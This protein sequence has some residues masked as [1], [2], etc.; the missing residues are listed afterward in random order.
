[1]RIVKL[2]HRLFCSSQIAFAAQTTVGR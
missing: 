1:M 2:L